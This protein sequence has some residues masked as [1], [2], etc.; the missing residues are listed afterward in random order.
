MNIR[1]IAFPNNV[2]CPTRKEQPKHKALRIV[3]EW[4]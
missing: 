2:F 3:R 4:H 1:R